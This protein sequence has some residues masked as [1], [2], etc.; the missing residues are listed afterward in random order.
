MESRNQQ[1]FFKS[2]PINK[3]Q[4][5][6]QSKTPQNVASSLDKQANYISSATSI[7]GTAEPPTFGNFRQRQNKNL[8]LKTQISRNAQHKSEASLRPYGKLPNQNKAANLKDNF[9]AGTVLSNS[10]KGSRKSSKGG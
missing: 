6:Y 3:V 9:V 8:K 4:P 1:N 7:V 5:A 10:Y 2:D